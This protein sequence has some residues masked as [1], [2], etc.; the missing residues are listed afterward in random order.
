M[1]SGIVGCFTYL[2]KRALIGDVI[3]H[4]VLP[5]V[6]IAFMLTGIKNPVSFVIGAIISGLISVWAVDFI[7]QRSKLKPDTILALILSVFFGFG[8]LLLTYVQRGGNAAQSGLDS[9]LFGKAASMSLKDVQIFSIIAILNLVAIGVFLRG[10]QLISFDETYAKSIGFKV[11]FLKSALAV[12]TVVTVAIGVQA[13]GVVLMAALLISPAAGARFMT[14]NIRKMLLFSG[15]IGS[16]AGIAGA[17]ISS[18]GLGMP[19]GPWVVV[20]LS[21]IAFLA[22]LFGKQRGLV[23]RIRL[24]RSNQ[25]KISNENVL[26]ALYKISQKNQHSMELERLKEEDDL[27][28]MPLVK[29]LKRLRRKELVELVKGRVVLSEQGVISARE[30]IRKHRLWELY[31]SKYFQLATDHLHDDAEGIEHVITPEIEK[32]L[33][34]LLEYPDKDPHESEIPY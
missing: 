8:I 2:R 4:A 23:S 9:F 16:I 14:N 31:L 34:E 21:A 10:F 25:L 29:V 22:I 5:G 18:T 27:M 24:R 26:K 1:A 17:L 15:V 11:R 13:V 12:I 7:Q 20:C 28:H 33:T 6:T 3:S 30:V 32:N 19:T